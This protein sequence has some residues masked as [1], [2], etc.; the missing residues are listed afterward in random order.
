VPNLTFRQRLP[1][2]FQPNPSSAD[3]QDS[4]YPYNDCYTLFVFPTFGSPELCGLEMRLR[5]SGAPIAH[6]A[7]TPSQCVDCTPEL[8]AP[9]HPMP[10]ASLCA[11]KDRRDAWLQ[12]SVPP[13]KSR[14]EVEALVAR[15]NLH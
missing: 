15:V 1:Y 6:L 5:L 2:L 12:C 7:S 4:L 14:C 3:L 8:L 13:A 9:S 10:S 11:A